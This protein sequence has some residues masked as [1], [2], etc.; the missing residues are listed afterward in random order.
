MRVSFFL[1]LPFLLL[2]GGC[3]RK[4]ALVVVDPPAANSPAISASEDSL[5]LEVMEPALVVPP[6]PKAKEVYQA[7]PHSAK[8]LGISLPA[9][10]NTCETV[11]EVW[12]FDGLDACQLLI[13]TTEGHLFAV[14]SLPQGYELE[15]GTRIRFGFRYAEGEGSACGRE[16]ALIRITCMQLLRGSS[17]FS[18][19]FV[20][21]A[22]DEPAIWVQELIEEL[23]ANYVTRFPW[24]DNRYVYLFETSD[25][26]YLYDCQGFLLCQPKTNCLRF[27]EDFSLGKL[28]YEG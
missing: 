16:D 20:C 1:I 18:R 2:Y 22:F 7:F 27:I 21:E 10:R 4:A 8:S 9:A 23:R 6:P 13:Q 14:A 3:Q 19:P 25:G 15:G 11:G 24:K 5:G 12:D 28:I 26:Q 17:G